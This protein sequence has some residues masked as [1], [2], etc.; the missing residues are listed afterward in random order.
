MA[1]MIF[2]LPKEKKNNFLLTQLEKN[3]SKI[4]K[5]NFG[6]SKRETLTSSEQKN[7]TTFIQ[8]LVFFAI[9]I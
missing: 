6:Y 8:S 4:H 2:F 1:K 5:N 7:I 3:F 9:N